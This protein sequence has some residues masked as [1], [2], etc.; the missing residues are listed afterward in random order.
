MSIDDNNTFVLVKDSNG[1]KFLCPIKTI[2]RSDSSGIESFDDCLEEDVTG[3]Y[4]GIINIKL[5]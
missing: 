1:E 5:S 3:R 2:K 4:A